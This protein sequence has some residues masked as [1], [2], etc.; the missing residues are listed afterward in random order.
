MGDEDLPVE[1]VV[2]KNSGN[3]PHTYK[4]V[5]G[6]EAIQALVKDLLLQEEVCIDTE[7]TGINANNVELVGLSFSYK[8]HEGFYVPIENETDRLKKY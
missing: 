7:T 5:V 4:A 1:L 6:K 3:T 2:N 8:E